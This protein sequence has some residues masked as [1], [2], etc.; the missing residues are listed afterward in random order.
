MRNLEKKPKVCK[1]GGRSMERH[2]GELQK[3]CVEGHHKQ[4]HC[5]EVET[6]YGGQRK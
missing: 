4:G 5:L 3:F 1:R 2:R 6:T